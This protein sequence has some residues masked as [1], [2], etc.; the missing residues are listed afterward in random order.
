MAYTIVTTKL[1][2]IPM[3]KK[4]GPKEEGLGAKGGAK[5][6]WSQGASS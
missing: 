2:L 3:H 4:R 6:I 5:D 1:A